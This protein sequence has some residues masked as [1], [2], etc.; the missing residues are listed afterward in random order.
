MT[1][2]LF[3]SFAR[4]LPAT[5]DWGGMLATAA[6]LTRNS[7][8]QAARQVARKVAAAVGRA[9]VDFLDPPEPRA[10]ATCRTCR[11]GLPRGA[12]CRAAPAART[13]NCAA[14][15]CCAIVPGAAALL[16]GTVRRLAAP[17]RRRLWN[18]TP[19][20][21]ALAAE[22]SELPIVVC[23]RPSLPDPVRAPR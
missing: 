21:A 3:V 22:A 10:G 9:G 14:P 15:S 7:A 11:P 5:L 8:H 19:Q 18:P 6:V 12:A 23:G 1:R 20:R 4:G 13:W 16:H 2:F 17:D